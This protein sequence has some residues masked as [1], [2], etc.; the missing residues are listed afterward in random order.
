M[1]GYTKQR[2]CLTGFIGR[3]EE[4]PTKNG[5]MLVFS[6]S[7]DESY[8]DKETEDY[9]QDTEWHQCVVFKKHLVELFKKH[10]QN[11]GLITLEGKIK[12]RQYEDSDGQ[13]QWAK[14]VIVSDIMTP[15]KGKVP[16]SEA[17]EDSGQQ[18]DY[19]SAPPPEDLPE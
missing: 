16:M 7:T 18:A 4:H 6:V 9:I 15:Y 10:F 5:S 12:S 13:T 1:A 19:A 8:K 3:W 14:E 2:F 11:K 17:G